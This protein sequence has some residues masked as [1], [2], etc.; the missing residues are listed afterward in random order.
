MY[1]ICEFLLLRYQEPLSSFLTVARKTGRPSSKNTV[2]TITL[3]F[4]IC[5]YCISGSEEALCHHILRRMNLIAALLNE[6]LEIISKS[7]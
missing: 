2:S 1:C 3:G 7:V 6:E 5:L 4:S